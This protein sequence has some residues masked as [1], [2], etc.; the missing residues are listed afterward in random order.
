[1]SCPFSMADSHSPHQSETIKKMHDQFLFPEC[2]Q[3]QSSSQKMLQNN[4][5]IFYFFFVLRLFV[6]ELHIGG[7]DNKYY[8]LYVNKSL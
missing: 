4:C 5:L 2:H 1:M 3:N 7:L 6:T 8:I